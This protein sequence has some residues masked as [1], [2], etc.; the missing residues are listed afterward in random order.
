MGLLEILG[1]GF[2]VSLEEFSEIEKRITEQYP[3]TL[4]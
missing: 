1:I 4:F 3:V 2:D